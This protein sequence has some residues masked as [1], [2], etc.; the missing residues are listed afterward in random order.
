MA[1]E[2]IATTSYQ[3]MLRSSVIQIATSP[4]RVFDLVGEEKKKG[5]WGGG[6]GGET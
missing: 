6:G 2:S 4:A 5:E 1:V 3:V